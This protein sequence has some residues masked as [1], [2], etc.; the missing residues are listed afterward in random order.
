MRW[1]PITN[2]KI[3]EVKFDTHLLKSPEV[4]GR[5]YQFGKLFGTEMREYLLYRYQHTCQYCLGVSGDKILQWEHKVP[6]SRGGSNSEMN[7]TLSCRRCNSEKGNLTPEEWLR[8]IGKPRTKLDK[9]WIKTLPKIIAQ[10][11]PPLRDA[12]VMN[13]TRYRLFDYLELVGLTPTLHPGWVTKRNRLD[14]G[15]RKDH[16][17]DATCVGS[18]GSRVYIPKGMRVLSVK[19]MGHTSRVM[20]RPDRFGFPR[21]RPKGPS[22]AFTFKTGDVCKTKIPTGKYLGGCIGRLVVRSSG[23]FRLNGTPVHY[24]FVVRIQ[25]RD[26]YSY[27]NG[28]FSHAVIITH[29]CD[30]LPKNSGRVLKKTRS[31][32]SDVVITRKKFAINSP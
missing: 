23:K 20:C 21:T 8:A 7:A 1:C 22:R 3:E 10:K 17:I 6:R 29:T 2:A 19:A 18:V 5:R 9:V 30:P 13:A 28:G 31:G 14:Q 12:A 32:D 27:Q 25:H 24:R 16:W 15:Y 26:G 4:K 11:K